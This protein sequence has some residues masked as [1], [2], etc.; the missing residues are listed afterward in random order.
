[1]RCLR[2]EG[3]FSTGCF[4]KTHM[5]SCS[6]LSCALHILAGGVCLQ[7]GKD[8]LANCSPL[9]LSPLPE[10]AEIP[11]EALCTWHCADTH[12]FTLFKSETGGT[13]LYS[14]TNEVLYH[15]SLDAQLAPACP[16]DAAFLCQF[17]FDSLP[18]GRVPRLLV[19]DVLTQGTPMHRGERLRSLQHCLPQPLCCVQWIGYAGC[20]SSQ[21]VAALPHSICGVLT[22]GV[23][24]LEVLVK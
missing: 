5:S 17:T 21:F 1:M 7:I 2:K 23:C 15:A 14:H 9:S 18:E 19:F 6:S 20:L 3:V 22:L 16:K 10:N 11:P 4:R 8:T 12:F 24:P 13:L